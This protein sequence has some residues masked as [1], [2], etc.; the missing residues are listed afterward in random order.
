M[1]L[2][3]GL[4][5]LTIAVLLAFSDKIIEHFAPNGQLAKVE[6]EADDMI[7]HIDDLDDL[8]DDKT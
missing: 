3:L 1:S 5:A 8:H 2:F 7:L 6:T 4:L